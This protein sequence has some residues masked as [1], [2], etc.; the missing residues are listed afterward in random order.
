MLRTGAPPNAL[1]LKS[2]VSC[3]NSYT[4]SF[5]LTFSSVSLQSGAVESF[6]NGGVASYIASA[7]NGHRLSLFLIPDRRLATK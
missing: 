5:F 2:A 1:Y 7:S 3:A 6:F 4:F